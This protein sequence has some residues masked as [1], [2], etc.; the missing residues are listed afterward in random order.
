M[1]S[2][3]QCFIS[4]WGSSFV[5]TPWGGLACCR[6]ELVLDCV[7]HW[8]RIKW[9]LWFFFLFSWSIPWITL[10]NFCLLR[11]SWV[12]GSCCIAHFFFILPK[13]IC[14]HFK[15]FCICTPETIFL[16]C[17]VFVI[18]LISFDIRVILASHEELRFALF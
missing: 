9:K 17:S 2:S 10:I 4:S 15:G 3:L 11:Q 7:T 8:L 1:F 18:F 13:G 6:D 16:S 12:P 14:S 5:L